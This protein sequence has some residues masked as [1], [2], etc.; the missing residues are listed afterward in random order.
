MLVCKKDGFRPAPL[1]GAE[2]HRWLKVVCGLETDRHVLGRVRVDEEQAPEENYLGM[3]CGT[4][5]PVGT[6]VGRSVGQALLLLF[7]QGKPPLR[8]RLSTSCHRSSSK[9]QNDLGRARSVFYLSSGESTLTNRRDNA[10]FCLRKD[11]WE[12]CDMAI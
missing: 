9:E 8:S 2:F 12:T 1:Y 6:D 7:L 4:C 5:R 3:E 11:I 10:R